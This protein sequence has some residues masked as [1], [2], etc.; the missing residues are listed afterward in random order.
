MRIRP[1]RVLVFLLTAALMLSSCGAKKKT[2]TEIKRTVEGFFDAAKSGDRAAIEEYIKTETVAEYAESSLG[3]D[4]LIEGMLGDMQELAGSDAVKEI[5][6]TAIGEAAKHITYTFDSIDVA[7]GDKANVNVTIDAP[8]F[9]AADISFDR[10]FALASEVLGVDVTSEQQ[11]ARLVMDRT[12]LSAEELKEMYANMSEN[13]VADQLLSSF[14]PEMKELISRII[15]DMANSG[16]TK[17]KV[18]IDLSRD[19]DS[20]KITDMK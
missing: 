3:L 19:G 9:E 5:T 10:L 6:A 15:E 2:E 17:S 11:L 14:E 20:W 1:M 18:S 8:D 13:G 16:T 12:G 4:W 7:D